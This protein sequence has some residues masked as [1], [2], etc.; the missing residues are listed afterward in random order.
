[1]PVAHVL[2]LASGDHLLERGITEARL[3]RCLPERQGLQLGLAYGLLKLG[4]VRLSH[5]CERFLSPAAEQLGFV[6]PLRGQDGARGLHRVASGCDK[7]DI[8][9]KSPL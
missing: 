5:S 7:S 6:T 9:D 4:G 1:M 2:Q 8:C 3:L